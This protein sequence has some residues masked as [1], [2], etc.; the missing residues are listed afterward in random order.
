MAVE[1]PIQIKCPVENIILPHKYGAKAS[2]P[3]V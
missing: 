1:I 2:A 3:Q